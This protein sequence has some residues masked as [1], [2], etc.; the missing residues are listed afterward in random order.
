MF[1]CLF[2]KN[3]NI[4][5]LSA[6]VSP[7]RSKAENQSVNRGFNM[8]WGEVPVGTLPKTPQHLGPVGLST[9]RQDAEVAHLQMWK[10]NAS[11]FV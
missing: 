1:N 4:V 10:T 5:V 9:K 7:M 3:V 6:G 8:D 11:W 2:L